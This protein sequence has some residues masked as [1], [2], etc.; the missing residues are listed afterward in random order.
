MAQKEVRMRMQA[1]RKRV[2]N[3]VNIGRTFN[4]ISGRL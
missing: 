3:I 2:E 1:V 4:K